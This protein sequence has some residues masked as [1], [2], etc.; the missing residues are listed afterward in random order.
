MSE[1]R[2]GQTAADAPPPKRSAPEHL[3]L[4]ALALEEQGRSPFREESLVVAAWERAPAAFGLRGY[5]DRHPSSN[6]VIC[7]IVGNRRLVRRGLLARVGA[8]L[9]ALTPAGRALAHKLSGRPAPAGAA[10]LLLRLEA[11]AA[12]QMHRAGRTTNI[13]FKDAAAF[14]GLSDGDCGG[15]LDRRLEL[16]ASTLEDARQRAG[17]GAWVLEDGRE[18]SADDVDRL[19]RAHDYLSARFARILSLMR[20]RGPDRGVARE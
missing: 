18:V 5:E 10:G 16:V 14:W 12:A 6:R 13:T 8:K 19:H 9:Y 17:A 2:N 7:E 20:S 11:S 15:Q 1:Q 3:L 4:A